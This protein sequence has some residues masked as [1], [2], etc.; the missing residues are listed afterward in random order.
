[1]GKEISSTSKILVAIAVAG[2][3]LLSSA[4]SAF[5]QVTVPG[6]AGKTVPYTST[7]AG[8]MEE[9][10]CAQNTWL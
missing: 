2:V 8:C 6:Y 3:G 4:T 10:W 7:N 5:A 9:T 1:M